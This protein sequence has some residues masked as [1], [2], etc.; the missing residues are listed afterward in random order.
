MTD[1]EPYVRF[2]ATYFFVAGMDAED[3]AQE[4]RLAAWLA[5]G[6]ERIAARRRILD[7]LKF[8]QRRPRFALL[9]DE[10]VA[11]DS[12]VDLI[13]ARERL[14]RVLATPLTD[15]ERSAL[16]RAIRGEPIARGEK[17]AQG[18]LARARRKVACAS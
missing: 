15:R 3:L 4:A 8:A 6:N 13:A 9:V 17:A 1:L 11:P 18:A 5:P 14:R 10:P 7:L 2:L 12:I 16:G